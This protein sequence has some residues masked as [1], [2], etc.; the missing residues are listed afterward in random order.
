MPPR[1][2]RVSAPE[3]AGPCAPSP[4]ALDLPAAEVRLRRRRQAY[5]ATLH[6]ASGRPD[7]S[8]DPTRNANHQAVL[9]PSGYP[10]SSA[11]LPRASGSPR[12]ARPENGGARCFRFPRHSQITPLL[13]FAA[14]SK[15]AWHEDAPPT[16]RQIRPLRRGLP[17]VRPRSAAAGRQIEAART[18]SQRL[19]ATL[20]EL[21][22]AYDIRIVNRQGEITGL[23]RVPRVNPAKMFIAPPSASIATAPATTRALGARTVTS[24]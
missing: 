23:W 13:V 3:V 20:D 12:R 6:A 17:G 21:R 7:E 16:C 22:R 1:H 18:A 11:R 9:A 4:G 8:C 10:L 5:P 19:Q 15:L 2:L 14:A 24:S